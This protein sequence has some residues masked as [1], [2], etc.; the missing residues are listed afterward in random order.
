MRWR[1][2]HCDLGGATPFVTF[3]SLDGSV[4]IANVR[5]EGAATAGSGPDAARLPVPERGLEC[6]RA[7][8]LG[9]VIGSAGARPGRSFE[10]AFEPGAL[11]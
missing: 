2:R 1:I 5:L 4:R 9:N 3:E 6:V 7:A 10:L 8:L 11:E